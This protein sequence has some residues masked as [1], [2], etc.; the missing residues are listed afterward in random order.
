LRLSKPRI[1]KRIVLE[2]PSGPGGGD[3]ASPVSAPPK[4]EDDFRALFLQ[5]AEQELRAL[6]TLLGGM[7]WRENLD[8]ARRRFHTLRGSSATLDF[9]EA[10]AAAA[11]GEEIAEDAE[12][13]RSAG[14]GELDPALWQSLISQGRAVAAALDLTLDWPAA[15]PDS[16]P[17]A[18]HPPDDPAAGD[19][20]PTAP[21]VAV[22]ERMTH[23]GIREVRDA[24]QQWLDGEAG[25]FARLQT[26]LT[27]LEHDLRAQGHQAMA[28]SFADMA[29]L[30]KEWG[31]RKPPAAMRAVWVRCLDDAS[32]HWTALAQ[33]PGL[34][35]RRRWH[36]VFRSLR[37]ALAAEWAVGGLEM[38][39]GSVVAV[40]PDMLEAFV[41]EAEGLFALMEQALLRWEKGEDP[42]AQRTE[43]RRHFHTLKGAANSIGLT[44]M[45]AG[46]HLLE[47]RMESGETG[48]GLIP[49]VLA[50][51]D[52]AR[53]HVAQLSKNPSAPWPHDWA[54]LLAGTVEVAST[55]G[56]R[57]L[58]P[59]RVGSFTEEA[60]GLLDP[61][62]TALL[63]WERGEN[64]EAR[65]GELR[66]HFHTLKGAAH[67]AGLGALGDTFHEVEDFLQ[68]GEASG[69]E[70]PA[71]ILAGLDD[72]RKHLQELAV[73]PDA[74]WTGDWKARRAAQAKPAAGTATPAEA[75]SV[76]VPA[77][78]LREVMAWAGELLAGQ[79]QGDA[80]EQDLAEAKTAF[81]SLRTRVVAWAEEERAGR[82]PG[83]TAWTEL[84][85]E[86]SG[87]I[88]RWA[89]LRQRAAAGHAA[90]K[91]RAR[92]LQTELADFNMAPVSGLF[93]RL[94]RVFRD[95][96]QAERKEANLHLEGGRTRLDRGIIDRLYSPMLH[97]LRNAVAHGIEPPDIR[98]G[99]G[100]PRAG[101]VRL[102]ALAQPGHVVFE[103]EDDGG[104]IRTDAVLSRAIARGLIPAGTPALR[105]EEAVRLLFT[106]GFST[107]D[108]TNE[109][110]GRGVGLDVVKAEV[111][112][113]GGSVAVRF[114][115]GRGAVWSVRVPLN[116]SASEA[117]VVEA[118]RLTVAIPLGYVQRCI[119]LDASS[120][121]E[122]GGKI[123]AGAEGLPFYALHELL[124]SSAAEDSQHGVVV[125]GGAFQAV[126]GVHR[127]AARREVVR[128]DPG[129]ILGRLPFLSGI[130][131]EADGGL[132][133]LLHIPELL[134]QLGRNDSGAMPVPLAAPLNVLVVDDSASVRLAHQ[135][136]LERLGCRTLTAVDGVD[137]LER[138]ESEPVDL[139]L[140]DLEMPRMDGLALTQAL[141]A[142]PRW[143]T[144]PVIVVT[145]RRE[146]SLVETL[147][148]AGAGW[149]PKP[150]DLTL[151]HSA[152]ARV[153]VPS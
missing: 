70:A 150:M 38:E 67:S 6:A 142:D 23:D 27:A 36:L 47:D 148:Q 120:L 18:A 26:H 149:L 45:G 40:D 152:L 7:K 110:A 80:V 72:L 118:G 133:P 134:R 91:Q 100:K 125:D 4:A 140:S 109:V 68:A 138:L 66:R 130:C 75:T 104:G 97:L 63:A 129:P 77:E 127:L 93:R 51:L 117:L 73:R 146:A 145:S 81:E 3:A 108:T 20:A 15:A 102:A 24:W 95:A 1:T 106:P 12:D 83:L 71:W 59:E 43:L 35:W 58:D 14:G 143:Q 136:L 56:A 111:E 79:V 82:P 74:P 2:F 39:T 76:R 49:R 112:Q 13:G 87:W 96:L 114:T 55:V 128:K 62:E 19:Q 84:E 137:A 153:G 105:D 30:L 98:E 126:L 57:A 25:A 41:E 33:S 9:P 141:R 50:C 103:V 21:V 113:M 60:Q 52:Q 139:V 64:P 121:R 94:Q 48:L 61:M 42:Q 107:K 17:V 90:Q 5:E 16:T 132:L 86:L 11:R 131:P 8:H 31:D 88:S 32:A 44:A 53:T 65:I 116:L 28:H 119:R 89:A 46:F 22:S 123:V 115:P 69:T 34:P 37:V 124:G 135:K 151:L 85:R 144:L 54:S 10:A 122:E 147:K 101:R 29:L 78:R 92:R 99:S